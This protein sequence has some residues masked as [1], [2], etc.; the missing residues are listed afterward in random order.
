MTQR[1]GPW[2]LN[3]DWPTSLEA[4][5]RFL[6]DWSFSITELGRLYV[7]PQK[8]TVAREDVLLYL[9]HLD[10]LGQDRLPSVMTFDFSRIALAPSR[11]MEIADTLQHYATRHALATVVISGGRG[12]GGISV[13]LKPSRLRD[14]CSP[15]QF[16]DTARYESA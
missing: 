6:D 5:R 7:R 15:R 12:T 2:Q 14:E 8:Q 9:R 10:V 4:I 1:N 11:W 16:V 3:R 13:L